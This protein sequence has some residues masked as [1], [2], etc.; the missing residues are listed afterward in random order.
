[1]AISLLLF[2]SL[3]FLSG[4]ASLNSDH[5]CQ[6]L[7]SDNKAEYDICHHEQAVMYAVSGRDY[8]DHK[9]L[10]NYRREEGRAM[11]ECAL[12]DASSSM[13]GAS[14]KNLCLADIAED[15]EDP[16]ICDNIQGSAFLNIG[17]DTAK[18]LCNERASPVAPACQPIAILLTAMLGGAFYFSRRKK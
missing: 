9:D 5:T 3:I 1:M 17:A 12:L 4:C 16:V 13:P 6:P 7:T 2:C 14:T 18:T 15:L 11:S 8:L 10:P